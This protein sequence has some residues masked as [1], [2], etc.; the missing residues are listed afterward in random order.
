MLKHSFYIDFLGFP[1][2]ILVSGNNYISDCLFVRLHSD[3]V[4]QNENLNIGA[5]VEGI[6]DFDQDLV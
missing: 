2:N 6:R 1:R 4:R 3:F 5:L